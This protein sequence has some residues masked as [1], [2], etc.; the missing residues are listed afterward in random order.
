MKDASKAFDRVNR[1]KLWNTMF[2]M[3]IRPVLILSLKAYYENF[4]IIV[5]NGKNYAA[6]FLTTFGVKQ[7][8]CISPNLYKLYSEIIAIVIRS[9]GFGIEYGKMK[10]DILMYAD[11]VIL[12]TSC[13]KEAQIMLNELSIISETHQ[14]KFNASKTNVMV[15]DGDHNEKVELYLCK[16]LITQ[17]NTIKYL[18]TELESSHQNKEHVIK[19]KK[20][21]VIALNNLFNAGIINNQMHISSRVKLFKTY[22][23]PLLSYG[24]DVL[25]L[26]ENDLLDLKRCEGNALKDIIGI[27]RKCHTSPIYAALGM[28]T[29]VESVRK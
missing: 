28:E 24:C 13:L 8:G 9:L 11:D 23:K 18:G 25:D 16:E 26:N 6:P 29:T 22:I 3:K 5:N 1:T 4:Y 20:A 14:I 15:M 10:I 12:M 21:V 2:D 7:G 19:R 17:T 27:T